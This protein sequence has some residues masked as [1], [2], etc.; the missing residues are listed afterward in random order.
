MIKKFWNLFTDKFGLTIIHPQF[1]MLQFTRLAIEKIKSK[2]RGKVIDIGCG[3]APYKQEILPFLES[4]T[5]VDNPKT[6]KLYQSS[7][8]VDVYADAE[9]LPFD[10]S[11]FDTA[12]MLQVLEY[13]NNPLQALS[14]TSRVLKKGGYLILTSPFLYPIHDYP[15]DRNRYTEEM[16]TDL[17]GKAGFSNIKITVQGG[18]LDFWFQSLNVFLFKRIQDL[19]KFKK[20]I[21]GLGI[22]IFLL[23]ITPTL[24][25]LT[26]L[27][28]LILK[29]LTKS[30][31]YPNYFPL[32]YLI[33]ASKR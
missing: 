11:H 23:L 6:A 1:I 25:L 5:G 29:P 24:V 10:S 2:N 15:H 19:L 33:E 13:I 16:L 12:L 28:C 32:N 8:T 7:Q 17:L 14:E 22:L 31:N 30:L 3:R 4:Y 26:N 20:D 18:F 27:L 9:K 21:L